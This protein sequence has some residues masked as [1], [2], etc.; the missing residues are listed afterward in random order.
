MKNKDD[1]GNKCAEWERESILEC[2]TVKWHSEKQML[3][4]DWRLNGAWLCARRLWRWIQPK[5]ESLIEH[6]T[7]EAVKR[8]ITGLQRLPAARGNK[9]CVW[10][11]SNCLLCR[12]CCHLDICCSC[13]LTPGPLWNRL[14]SDPRGRSQR[15]HGSGESNGEKG[16]DKGKENGKI[17]RSEYWGKKIQIHFYIGWIMNPDGCTYDFNVSKANRAWPSVAGAEG[18]VAVFFLPSHFPPVTLSVITNSAAV[19]NKTVES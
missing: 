1:R 18:R 13:S 4:S 8:L 12:R 10:I 19:Q 6:R 16:K 14:L 17:S 7:A 3:S 2:E 9:H 15:L 5:A 11:G